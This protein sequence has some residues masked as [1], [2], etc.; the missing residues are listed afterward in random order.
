VGLYE[1]AAK[2]FGRLARSTAFQYLLGYSPAS[3]PQEGEFREIRVTLKRRGLTALYRHGYQAGLRLDEPSDLR[4]IFA[5]SRILE[6]VP[7]SQKLADIA[8]TVS[9]VASRPQGD[10]TD[11]SVNVAIDPKSV[12]FASTGNRYSAHLDVAVFVRDAR[13]K[14]RRRRSGHATERAV[15]SSR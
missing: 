1:D 2:A 11:L 7:L 3:P 6:A 8:M 10:G 13:D 14:L 15:R 12:K 5:T 9:A 4:R